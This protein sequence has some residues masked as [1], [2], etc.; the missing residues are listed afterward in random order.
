MIMHVHPQSELVA[1]VDIGTQGVRVVVADAHGQ[2]VAHASTSFP[3][4]SGDSAAAGRFEQEPQH[5]WDATTACLRQATAAIGPRRAELKALAVTATSGTICLLDAQG[6]AIRPAIMYSD[7][8]AHDEAAWLNQVA[9]D[10][11]GR[12]G[13]RFDAS[14]GLPKL[15]W[16][17]RHEPDAVAEC[18]FYAHAGD[19]ISGHLA[20]AYGVSD[21]SQALKSGYDL[22]EQRWPDVFRTLPDVPF[23]CFPDIVA[24]GTVIGQV[25]Q[26]ASA[27]TGLPAGVAVVAG[28]TDSCAAQVAGGAVASGQWISVL[29]TTLA[30]KGVTETLLH[31]PQG[32]VYSHRHPDGLWLP[33]SASNTGGEVLARRFAGANLQQLDAQAALLTP[34]DL[35]CYPLERVGERF[36]FACESAQGFVLGN[37]ETTEHSYTA[38]LEG[39]GYV[40]RLAYERF[41]QLGATITPPICVTGGGARSR[42]WLQIRANILNRPLA[43]PRQT[44]SAFGA[45]VVAAGA[46]L[47]PDL[48]T[49]TRAMVML[50]DVV[51][52]GPSRAHYDERYE[53]F[54]AVCRER[55]YLHSS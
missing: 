17:Q 19:V 55:G 11:T 52:P 9:T 43:V 45:A 39:V 1:G 49:A 53:Q 54:V 36:P 12:H 7:W 10:V 35:V 24:P 2:V 20:G 21:W 26:D 23:S 18:R 32:K 40:E 16:L 29:G 42:V 30:F 27:A 50:D 14:F 4:D 31:D 44:E 37:P 5:W 3:L 15:V 51:E 6:R 22:R 28:M 13:Y 38:C 46:V 33:G 34:T 48:V 41:A 25:T 8:R 47:Y